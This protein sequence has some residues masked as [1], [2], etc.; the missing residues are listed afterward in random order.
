MTRADI[1]AYGVLTDERQP[2]ESAFDEALGS[3]C[4]LRCL[5]T[6]LD[7]ATA[8]AAEGCEIVLT[9]VSDDLG[10]EV[11]RTLAAG[12][13]RFVAHR[14]TGYDTID[15]AAARD[16]GI[17][18]ARVARYSPYSVAEFA[19]ALALAVSRHVVRASTRAREFDFRLDGL[20]GREFHGRTV[21]ILGTGRIGAAFAT[22]AHGF[23][24][25]LLGHDPVEN[26][27]CRALGLEYVPRE[28]L[29]A[30]ADL[31]SLHAPLLPETRHLVGARELARMPDD[32]ILLNTGRGGLVDTRALL[33]T[34]RAGRLG[35]VG[36]D[37]YEGEAGLFHFDR[38]REV[39]TDDTLARLVTFPHVVVASHQ[40][41]FTREAVA[42]L[43]AATVGNVRDHLAGRT[44]VNTLV[45]MAR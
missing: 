26:P 32:A 9:G 34:L 25:R 42:Q 17:G 44:G 5:E 15:C 41:Y 7:A 30:E 31:L 1:L 3:R 29:F 27:D 23:G 12:G 39:L 21:G 36:L 13:T 8:P 14:A 33:D 45:D 6:P 2:L 38:S 18:V 22:I 28:R 35:G 37:V 40:A 20:L 24:I 10:A 16:L 43:V 19:W 11:L 4:A